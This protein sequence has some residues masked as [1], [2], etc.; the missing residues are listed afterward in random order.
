M[1]DLEKIADMEHADRDSSF[2][3]VKSLTHQ[4]EVGNYNAALNTLGSIAIN[5]ASAESNR[6]MLR[7]AYDM[8]QSGE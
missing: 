8:K 1:F 5:L 2:S 6:R 7:M 4:I 3:L